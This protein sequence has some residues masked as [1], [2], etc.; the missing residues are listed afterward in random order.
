MF[1][2]FLYLVIII[3]GNPEPF[4]ER[5]ETPDIKTCYEQLG[6]LL[7]QPKP[8]N[9]VMYQVSCSLYSQGERA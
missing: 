5:A 9:V 2:V 6:K 3:Q 1:K 4:I 8:N 7:A